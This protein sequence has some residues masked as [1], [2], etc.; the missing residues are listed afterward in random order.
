MTREEKIKALIDDYFD[1]SSSSFHI[2]V[3]KILKNGWLGYNNMTD[4]EIDE[5]Y[6]DRFDEEYEYHFNGDLDD[7]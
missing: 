6:K 3:V 1:V 2:F 4:E 5:E 7:E